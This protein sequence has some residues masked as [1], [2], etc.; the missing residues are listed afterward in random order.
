MTMESAGK[1]IPAGGLSIGLRVVNTSERVTA[2]ATGRVDS[3]SNSMTVIPPLSA[4]QYMR[5]TMSPLPTRIR[6]SHTGKPAY[7]F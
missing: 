6:V 5:C 4:T 2:T 3:F 7:H 1:S